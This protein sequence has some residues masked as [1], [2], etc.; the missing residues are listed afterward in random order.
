MLD[1]IKA[2]RKQISPGYE[3]VPFYIELHAFSNFYA[4]DI[5][6]KMPLQKFEYFLKKLIYKK[7]GFSEMN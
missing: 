5:V 2:I 4:I 7:L 1:S 6:K 3:I